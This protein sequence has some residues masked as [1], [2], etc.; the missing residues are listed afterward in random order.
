MPKA[1]KPRLGGLPPMYNFVLNPYPD[2][3]LSSCPFCSGKTGQRKLPLL[4]HVDPS[5]LIA[6]NYTCRYCQHCDLL[7][8]HKHEVEHL[9][10]DLFS[11]VA[12]EAIGNDYLIV[13]TVERSAWREGIQQPKPIPEMLPHVHDFKRHYQELR[14]SQ[15]GWYPKDKEPPAMEP[16]ESQEW[17]KAK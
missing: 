12:P 10:H 8:A 15:P 14:M 2:Q 9:L 4:I 13:G 7:L 1:K 3:R 6:L 5:S 16:P 17:V 11:R